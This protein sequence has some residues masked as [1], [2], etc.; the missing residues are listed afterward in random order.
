MSAVLIGIHYVAKVSILNPSD[1][2]NDSKKNVYVAV[3]LLFFF[4]PKKLVS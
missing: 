1:E 2:L 3:L 4:F